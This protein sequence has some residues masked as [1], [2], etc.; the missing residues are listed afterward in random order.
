[1][2]HRRGMNRPCPDFSVRQAVTR[3][4]RPFYFLGLSAMG[5]CNH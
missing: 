5:A 3:A 1:L 2:P 4:G